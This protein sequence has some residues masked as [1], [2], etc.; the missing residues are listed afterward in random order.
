MADARL[1][2]ERHRPRRTDAIEHLVIWHV[3]SPVRGSIH[4]FK[5]RL[6][7]VAKGESVVRY[8]N[9]AGKGDHRHIGATEK[10]YVFAGIAVL[11][12][13]FEA[14]VR[15]WLDEHPGD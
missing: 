11:L 9:E 7:F 13:D 3:P 1:A 8:D 15:R 6:S 14:D 5:Y 2:I 12:A 10:P 4:F